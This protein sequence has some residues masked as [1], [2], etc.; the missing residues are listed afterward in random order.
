MR[1]SRNIVAAVRRGGPQGA[2]GERKGR[3]IPRAL[4]A[5]LDDAPGLRRAPGGPGAP[6]LRELERWL[7]PGQKPGL[8]TNHEKNRPGVNLFY[9][10]STTV[11]SQFT[12]T[13][14]TGS[15]AAST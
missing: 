7:S 6:V 8:I 10:P 12:I 15:E 5:P 4:G 2:T 9:L 13:F 14:R 1:E 11:C 3:A